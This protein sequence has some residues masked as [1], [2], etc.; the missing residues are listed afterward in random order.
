VKLFSDEDKKYMKENYLKYTN[1]EIAEHL[2]Y[3]ERQIRG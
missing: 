2:G 3:T 1:K